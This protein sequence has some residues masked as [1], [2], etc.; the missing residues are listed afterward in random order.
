MEQEQVHE[1]ERL[2]RTK[3]RYQTQLSQIR[4]DLLQEWRGEEVD[5]LL[6]E[7]T[8][9]VLLA[10]GGHVGHGGH[11]GMGGHGELGE[12]GDSGVIVDGISPVGYMDEENSE[13][14]VIVDLEAGQDYDDET[15]TTASGMLCPL[16][17]YYIRVDIQDE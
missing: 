11:G 1:M 2:A 12:Q 14:D 10:G 7:A 13:G 15:T 8:E 3:I 9:K 6:R 4:E 5:A 17:H 16:K